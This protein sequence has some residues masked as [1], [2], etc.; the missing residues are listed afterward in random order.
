VR[1]PNSWRITIP[2]ATIRAR[3]T[4]YSSLLLHGKQLSEIFD[5]T[6]VSVACFDI[7]VEPL[8]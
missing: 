3:V 4:R 6:S 8:E 7:I 5:V 2:N 1:W